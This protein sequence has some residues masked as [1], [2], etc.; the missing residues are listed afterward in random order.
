MRLVS[1]R[2]FLFALPLCAFLKPARAAAPAG[3]P[4]AAQQFLD[5]EAE[6]S[7]D[8]SWSIARPTSAQ[9]VVFDYQDAKNFYALETSPTQIAFAQTNAGVRKI[10]AS[11]P[12]Q[13]SDKNEVVLQRRPWLMQLIV[14]DEIA[15]RGFDAALTAGKIGVAPAG[16][17]Q[18][19]VQPLEEVRFDDDFTRTGGT[20]DELWK[21]QGEWKLS[22]SSAHIS[23]KNANMSSNPFAFQTVAPGTESLAMTGRWFWDSYDARV[24]VRPAG[25]G[26]VGMAAY[27]KDAK[28]Y[29][30]FQWSSEEGDDARRLVRVQNG[31]TRV[32][33]TGKGAF[34]PKQ[35]YKIGLRTSPGYIEAIIDGVPVL[36]AANEALGQGGVGLWAKNIEAA[37]F[38]D[39]QVRSYDFLR[40]AFA[41]NGAWERATGKWTLAGGIAKG[42]DETAGAPNLLVTGARDW[43]GYR[44]HISA[45]VKP[46]ATLGYA[47]G[48][49]DLKNYTLFQLSPD[50][51]ARI[52]RVTNGAKNVLFEGKADLNGQTDKQDFARFQIDARNGALTVRAGSQLIAQASAPNLTNGRFA[53]MTQ[54]ATP[55]A[56]KDAVIYFPPPPEP[57]KVATRMEDDAYMVG[58]ASASGEWPPMPGQNGLEFWNS[59][60]F[61]GDTTLDF[62]WRASWRGKF[63]VALRAQRGKFES[64]YLLHAEAE[65]A[66]KPE[67]KKLVW[68]LSRDGKTLE[69]ASL[70]LS[71]LPDSDS[72]E[73]GMLH[74]QLAGNGVMLLAGETPVLS[75]L[76]PNP[77]T[78]T[79]MGVRSSGFRVRAEKMLV[80]SANRDDYTFTEAPVDFYAP[81]GRWNVFSRWPCYGDWSFFGGTGR[82]PT[83]WSK[84]TYGGD[85]VAEFYAH[86]QM[87]LPK[88]P[89][90]SH[91]G[92]LNVSICGDGKNPASGYSFVIAGRDNTATQ[93]LRGNKV[94]AERRDDKGWFHDTINHVMSWHR[95]WFYI[96]AE[97][98]AATKDGKD[99]VMV[100]LSRN[101]EKM[102]EFFD[103]D[104]LPLYKSG[105][106]VAFWTLD[107]TMMIARAKIEAAQ[108]GTRSLPAGLIEAAYVDLD[109][110]PQGGGLAPVGVVETGVKTAVVTSDGDGF[111][112]TNPV[113]GGIFAVDLNRAPL[114]ATP[115]TQFSMDAR[116]PN[117]VKI[118]LYAMVNGDWHTISISGDQRP[119]PMAPVVGK[120][121]VNGNSYR[122]D[123]G[124]ALAKA[125]PGQKEWKIETLRLGAMQGDP[126]RWIGFDGNDMDASYRI[127]NLNWK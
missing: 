89:G 39:V 2:L 77:P 16:W 104:P 11:A 79:A 13:W 20:G 45:Q 21:T 5:D 76:D 17:T 85:V 108:L 40:T 55:I 83:L 57:P 46:G 80:S 102:L 124:A 62:P 50:H 93:I 6:A 22:A 97:A 107:S 118:D 18:P 70:K 69:T 81:S 112:I 26:L 87:D 65:T 115:S 90:Y 19:R 31:V 44:A 86:P 37:E 61:F 119:D 32:L 91:P 82:H 120:A 15:L 51:T 12:I 114:T 110:A 66:D 27:V 30:A 98:R 121:N 24:A 9:A 23:D 41:N 35:W 84:R 126:Y 8:V 29:L 88:E 116:I 14:N 72:L 47:V 71:D 60:E 59:G 94:V 33:A 56:F 96:R 10:L 106:R 3:A 54:S 105:G 28:N 122:F 25:S 67:N 113:A 117:D 63:D 7:T 125:M 36:R 48:V 4:V 43:D 73:G 34:L 100:T 127:G 58:W 109:R 92:D 101:D 1:P 111:K 75:Y 99:G 74:L 38:D 52:I 42:A 95:T 103:A 68:T 49:R 64:G 78:G 123:I 53:L